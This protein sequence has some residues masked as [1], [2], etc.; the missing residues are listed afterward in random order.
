M[1]LLRLSCLVL[2]ASILGGGL[3]TTYGSINPTKV[4]A[5]ECK[6]YTFVTYSQNKNYKY[7]NED[8]YVNNCNSKCYGVVTKYR[9]ISKNNYKYVSTERTG[10]LTI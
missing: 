3:A 10:C 4:M 2:I 5:V 1:K 8:H 6:Y 9:L 7:V